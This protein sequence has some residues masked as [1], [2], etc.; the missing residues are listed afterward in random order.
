VSM[1]ISTIMIEELR[2][3][4]T[5]RASFRCRA[6]LPRYHAK[7]PGST[8]KRWAAAEREAGV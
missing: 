6:R 7:I 1:A 4:S 8:S 3:Y 2:A 5:Q